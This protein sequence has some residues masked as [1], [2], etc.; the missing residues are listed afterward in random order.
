MLGDINPSLASKAD[1]E[2]FR[3]AW[4]RIDTE[5]Q[6]FIASESLPELLLRWAAEAAAA[7]LTSASHSSRL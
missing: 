3:E 4:H 7:L 5:S 2:A 1:I 6:G